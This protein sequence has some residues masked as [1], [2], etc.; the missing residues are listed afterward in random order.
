MVWKQCQNVLQAL[1]GHVCILHS[2]INY[3][4]YYFLSSNEICYSKLM[5]LSKAQNYRF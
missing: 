5:A 1:N 2:V 3:V 4:Y